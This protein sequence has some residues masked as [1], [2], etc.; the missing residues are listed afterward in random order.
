MVES[1]IFISV[2]DYKQ[3][4]EEI[5]VDDTLIWRVLQSISSSIK[6]VILMIVHL[7]L[8]SLQ[9]Q[10]LFFRNVV[11]RNCRIILYFANNYSNNIHLLNKIFYSFWENQELSLEN[12]EK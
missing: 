1:V 3:L 2:Q 9:N 7:I 10:V 5:V 6:V 11:K 8:K 12:C 4:K